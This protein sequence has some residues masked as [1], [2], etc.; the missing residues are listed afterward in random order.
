MKRFTQEF[1]APRQVQ[2]LF[3]GVVEPLVN[4]GGLP[5]EGKEFTD[6]TAG[7]MYFARVPLVELH[8]KG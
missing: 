8:C 4:G 2:Q 1:C 6:L 3:V 7:A 5:Y